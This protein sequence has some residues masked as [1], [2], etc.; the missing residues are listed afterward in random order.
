[1]TI[2]VLIWIGIVQMIFLVML[3]ALLISHRILQVQQSVKQ[4]AE[5]QRV[6]EALRKFVAG[7]LQEGPFLRTVD[8][9]HF[10]SVSIV[11][12]QYSSQIRGE[13][14]ETIVD[15][16]RRSR[17]FRRLR[18]QARSRFWWRRLSAARL[19]SCMGR[20]EDE[21]LLR[22]LIVDEQP[23]IF[24]AAA[25]ALDRTES[26]ELL[27]TV[28][29][30][31]IEAPPVAR[32]ILFETLVVLRAQVLPSLATR[33]QTTDEPR[34]LM[35]WIALAGEL[36]ASDLLEYLLPHASSPHLEVRVSIAKTLASYPTPVARDA[37]VTLLF[38]DAWEVRSQAATALGAIRAVDAIPSLRR[39]L[40]DMN[41]WVRLRTAIALRQLGDRGVEVLEQVTEQD[42]PYALDMARYILGLT[43]AAVADYAG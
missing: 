38:D 13:T 16:V 31:A 4:E 27:D 11:L 20:P 17:W 35:A 33:L 24:L 7:E 1:M 15:A 6:A 8:D 30:Q 21:D 3:V 29:D 37:L 41:W 34:V 32:R 5:R 28:L 12:L 10:R 25:S 14:W 19:L 39:A 36:G 22:G 43:E 40:A 26:R 42:D 23:A 18:N 2:V 9:V